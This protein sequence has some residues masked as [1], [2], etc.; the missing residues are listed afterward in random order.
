MMQQNVNDMPAGRQKYYSAGAEL[1]V[2]CD[3]KW[4]LAF[5]TLWPII[6][7][8]DPKRANFIAWGAHY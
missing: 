8:E 5:L 4:S 6:L 7:I 3:H 2:D 1:E